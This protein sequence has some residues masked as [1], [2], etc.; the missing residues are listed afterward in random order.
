[1]EKTVTVTAKVFLS[2]ALLLFVFD[3]SAQDTT[4]QEI[5]ALNKKAKEQYNTSFPNALSVA[6]Q[7]QVRS[8]QVN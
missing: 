6:R 5:D 2:L 4:T 8:N 7:A 3:I 1:M